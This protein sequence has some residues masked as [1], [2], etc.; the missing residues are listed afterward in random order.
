MDNFV[1]CG[2]QFGDE[3]KGTFVDFLANKAPCNVVRYNGGSQASHTVVTQMGKVHKFS[4]L[5]SGMFNRQCDT[6]LS[7]NMV[8]NLENL[9]Y[10]MGNFSFKEGTPLSDLLK[11][12]HIDEDCYVVTPYHKLINKLRELSKG[13]N[14]RGTVGTGVSEVKYILDK[15]STLGLQIKDLACFSLILKKLQYIQNY[16]MEFFQDNKNII[17]KNTPEKM[18]DKLYLEINYTLRKNAYEE[19]AIE[20]VKSYEKLRNTF[21]KFS[22]ESISNKPITIFEGSQGLLIDGRYGIKPNTTY[23]DTTNKYALEMLQGTENVVKIGIA[24]AFNSRHG[25]GVFPTEDIEDVSSKITDENQDVS[26]WNGAIRFGWFDAVLLRYA[27]R[28]NQVEE[29]YLSSI[30]KLDAFET[31]KVCNEYQ[32]CGQI[33]ETFEET[34]DYYVQPDG[35]IVI[36][37][38]K[39]NT[40]ELSNYLKRS[41]KPLYIETKGWTQETSY[42]CNKEEL[43][44]ECLEYVKLLEELIQIPITLISVGPTRNNKIRIK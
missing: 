22:F 35:K 36:T 29:I 11:R 15:D 7:P 13:N 18:Q 44:S 6:Y 27:Q 9:I 33:D 31:I 21:G 34:F 5:G 17:L 37:D 30:D 20:Y 40:D 28:I 32:Y 23:L 8:V 3:G 42:Y 10:E 16:V 24:K 2:M 12:M 14:R 1:L 19:F 38:I 39:S 4:Q 41:C 26:F 25:L 43:P